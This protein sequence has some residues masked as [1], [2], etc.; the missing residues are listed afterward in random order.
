MWR[1]AAC[2]PFGCHFG[3]SDS[4]NQNSGGRTSNR[5]SRPVP[6]CQGRFQAMSFRNRMS[7]SSRVFQ[8]RRSRA[9][10]RAAGPRRNSP[11]SWAMCE[12]LRAG[13]PV[14]AGIRPGPLTTRRRQRPGSKAGPAGGRGAC[15]PRQSGREARSSTIIPAVGCLRQ[16]RLPAG[17]VRPVRRAVSR[18]CASG[19]W[20]ACASDNPRLAAFRVGARPGASTGR[21]VRHRGVETAGAVPLPKDVLCYHAPQNTRSFVPPCSKSSKRA[22]S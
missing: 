4:R 22:A 20:A 14:R 3:Q 6:G 12:S 11:P 13:S 9:D 17:S 18:W 8:V 5:M 7:V 2:W 1:R 19:R 10:E 15:P 21:G 16:R